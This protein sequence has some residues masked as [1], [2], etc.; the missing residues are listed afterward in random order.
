MNWDLFMP[1]NRVIAYL[2]CRFRL[3]LLSTQVAGPWSAP[4]R[5][6]GRVEPIGHAT[7]IHPYL[8][9]ASWFAMKP[10]E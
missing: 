6:K 9:T 8:Q 5:G 3:S 10:V 2:I 7:V 1:S 4:T